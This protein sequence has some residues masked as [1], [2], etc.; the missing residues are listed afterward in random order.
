[1][2][3]MENRREQIF[4]VLDASQMEIAGRFTDASPRTFAPGETIFS[5]G[6]RYTPA[7]LVLKGE[8]AIMRRDGLK[9]EAQ[10]ATMG[11]GDGLLVN[12]TNVLAVEIHLSSAGNAD[13]SFDLELLAGYLPSL[14][15]SQVNQLVSRVISD[16]TTVS[17][18]QDQALRDYL[19]DSGVNLDQA[20]PFL[21]SSKGGTAPLSDA[22][23]VLF[24]Q[25][26]WRLFLFK[27]GMGQSI[28]VTAGA[29]VAP[30]GAV[31]Q[32]HKARSDIAPFI[33]KP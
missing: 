21:L 17:H 3:L 9:S 6:E 31:E 25:A 22:G 13:L 2:S 15:Q 24:G 7:W 20:L 26:P 29:V 12:G 18:L 32:F 19:V 11:V 33:R 4:P 8:I 16:P 30:A 23:Q 1:M 5:M 14:N 27:Y 10:I 28:L